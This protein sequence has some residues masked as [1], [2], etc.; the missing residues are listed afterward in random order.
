MR[1]AV[2]AALTELWHRPATVERWDR[3]EPWAVARAVVSDGEVRRPVIVKWMRSGGAEARTESWRLATEAAAL[4]F[5]A[6]DLGIELAPRV[7]AAELDAGF[8]VLEDLAPRVALDALIDRDGV[9]AHRSRL[10][11][12]A[13]VLGE[14]GAVT[15][16]RV[17]KYRLKQTSDTRFTAQWGRAHQDADALGVPL[18]AA[19]ASELAAAFDELTSPGPFLALSNGDAESNNCLVQ[20]SGPADARLIDFEAA[21]YGHALRDAVCLHVPGPRWISVGDPV[22]DGLAQEYRRALAQGVP[23]AQDDRLYGFGLAA[24]CASWALLRLQRF[25]AL[26]ERAPG[27]HSRVQLVET[28]ESAARTA[29]AD[30]ALP[31][32]ASWFRRLGE[33]LRSRW[34]DADPGLYSPYS[35][36]R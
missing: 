16:G 36:R 9:A 30:H 7:T 35:P 4:R 6:D 29:S 12:F 2:E 18:P 19:A 24:A 10:A 34:P 8:L 31:A 21:A 17:E 22:A 14:L 32:L 5:L 3:I 13:G 23:E 26:D 20:E 1:A 11:A 25:A 27:D 33:T 15:A 28:M